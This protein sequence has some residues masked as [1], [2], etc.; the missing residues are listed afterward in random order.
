VNHTSPADEG[1]DKPHHKIDRMIG[2]QNAEI[3]N[4]RPKWIPGG[5]CNALLQIVFMSE[6]APLGP[7]A[8][9][10]GVN[11]ASNILAL[12]PNKFRIALPPKLLPAKR[13]AKIGTGWSLSDQNRPHLPVLE[14][15]RL[16]HRPP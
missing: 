11:D 5:Q 13:A 14:L 10:R 7:P 3:P 4:P 6:H 15:R 1:A 8:R 12:A 2:G 16:H 9:A